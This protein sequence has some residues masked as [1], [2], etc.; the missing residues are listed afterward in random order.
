MAKLKEKLKGRRESKNIQDIRDPKKAAQHSLKTRLGNDHANRVL[1]EGQR[2]DSQTDLVNE[3]SAR[4]PE[5]FRIPR[6][7][8]DKPATKPKGLKPFQKKK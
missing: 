4:K 1:Y 3:I 2:G 5:I 8:K 7:K 6:L